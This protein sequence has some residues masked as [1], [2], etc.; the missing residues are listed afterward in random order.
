MRFPRSQASGDGPAAV[1]IVSKGTEPMTLSPTVASCVS[2]IFSPSWHG[3][4]PNTAADWAFIAGPW[5]EPLR[6]CSS[7]V[8]CGSDTNVA[9]IFI[10]RLS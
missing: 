6:G 5:N 2:D 4:R 8:G 3:V 10:K 9:P 7:I 1:R